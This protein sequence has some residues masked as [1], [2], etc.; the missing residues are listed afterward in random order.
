[1]LKDEI[2]STHDDVKENRQQ[3]KLSVVLMIAL[4]VLL[5]GVGAL[6]FAEMDA[7]PVVE[8]KPHNKYSQ[9]LR[10]LD[11]VD[12]CPYSYYDKNGKPTGY[13][14]EFCAELANR[15]QMNLDYRLI[16]WETVYDR[17]ARDE[18]DV[19]FGANLEETR[20]GYVYT[21]PVS[22]TPFMVY[23]K[24][25]IE[26]FTELFDK[27]I[28]VLT[29]T[30]SERFLK[31]AG[32]G[33]RL[34]PCKNYS[35]T[36]S[37]LQSGE[38][39]CAVVR[40]AC[41]SFI[42]ERDGIHDIKPQIPVVNSSLTMGLLSKNEKL[43][44]D[45]DAAIAGMKADG[46]LGRLREKWLHQYTENQTVHGVLGNSPVLLSVVIMAV[47][48]LIGLMIR[49]HMAQMSM[50]ETEAYAQTLEQNFDIIKI[51]ASEY[52]SVYYVDLLSGEIIPY[53]MNEE[54]E[55]ML[56]NLFNE[57]LSFSEVFRAYVENSVYVDDRGKILE[58]GRPESIKRELAGKKS[59]TVV[60]RRLNEKGIPVYC[61][62][63]FVKVGDDSSE[64]QAV[65]LGFANRDE[66]ILT[67][68][69]NNYIMSEYESVYLVD[70][71][72]DSF[73][74]IKKSGVTDVDD[75][76]RPYSEVM[77]AFAAYVA[78]KDKAF[79]RAISNPAYLQEY[80]QNS[81]RREFMYELPG[82]ERPLRRAIVQAVER[83]AGE[84]VRFF[85]IG[86]LSLDKAYA[87][88]LLLDAELAEKSEELVVLNGRLS[89]NE[90]ELRKTLSQVNLY[91]KAILS[92][93]CGYFRANL[94]RDRLDSHVFEVIDG[95]TCDVNDKLGITGE[96]GFSEFISMEGG[97]F[98]GAVAKN[99]ECKQTLQRDILMENYRNGRTMTDCT[100]WVD[101][102]TVGRRYQQNVCYVSKDEDT[103]DLL[104]VCVFYDK[105]AEFER[106]Q[107]E[108][109]FK[110]AVGILAHSYETAY[111]LEILSGNLSLLHC[112]IPDKK[113]TDIKSLYDPAIKEYIG[114]FIHPDDREKLL[115]WIEPEF[116]RRSLREQSEIQMSFRQIKDG[117][118][119]YYELRYIGMPDNQAI[120][121]FEDRTEQVK[122]QYQYQIELEDAKMRAEAAS[123]AKTTFL[124]NMSHDIRTPMNAIIG[125][126]GLALKNYNGDER[127]KAYLDKIMTSSKHLLSLI[128]DVLD[129][130]RIE[131]GRIELENA[132]CNLSEIMHNLNTIIVG[133]AVAKNQQ[134]FIDSYDVV[135]EY[136]YCDSLRLN[137]VLLNLLSNAVKYTPEG[138]E[139]RVILTQLKDAP[140]GYGKYELRV[141][142]NGMGMSPE[143]AAKVF[144]P[145]ERE[146]SEDVAKIQGTGLG[147]AITKNIVDMM[148][149]TIEVQ[150]E[151]GKGMEFIVTVEFAV[152]EGREVPADDF[153]LK[154]KRVLVLDDDFAVCD[155]VSR[156]LTQLGMRAEWTLRGQEALLRAEQAIG[157]QDDFY[158]FIIDWQMPDMSGMQVARRLRLLVG[159]EVPI[160]VLTAYDWT[161]IED[162]ARAVGVTNFCSKPVFL[163][164][165]E[166]VL[167]PAEVKAEEKKVDAE[168]VLKD[169][170]VLLVDDNELN[171]DIGFEVL[172]NFGL[173]VELAENGQEAVDIYSAAAA[174]YYDIILMDV[175]MPVLDGYGATEAIRALE[176]KEKA[177]VPI[178]AMTANAFASDVKEAIGHGMN[179]HLAK[180]IDVEK[181]REVM[182]KILVK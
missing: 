88:K 78:D 91:R 1:M 84:K 29:N 23:S 155:G 30:T 48:L 147:M 150:T 35:E 144:E 15:L 107:K 55:E 52:S 80:M 18:A 157:M 9:T 133:Q 162:D 69:V 81:D 123:V 109:M 134:L 143:F 129:M 50:R 116:I 54:N 4:V 100:C 98:A 119:R 46:T 19:V 140:K 175:Q 121:A 77:T 179:A 86:F 97:F 132:P 10:V 110:A 168:L 56:G 126:T 112:N 73:R 89:D 57:G 39:D 7:E 63:K 47:V 145:F 67:R 178:V 131:S 158:A 31:N 177:A 58:A 40:A 71:L 12:F 166:R 125:F 128:N 173:Q 59:F 142:D 22:S 136:V 66:E 65:A 3:H 21:T 160:I 25:R 92:Q 93:S 161:T 138:G 127:L 11:D 82:A 106:Q 72:D 83:N 181:L 165:L 122:Q 64:P 148:G 120:Q 171:R 180:P 75:E 130:S 172:S 95:V 8:I 27:K 152:Q 104:V 118:T 70:V 42:L 26:N 44:R 159:P 94:T 108:K 49:M 111:V 28:A 36:I 174:G 167:K 43:A 170:R 149:G 51:L 62:M 114:K 96:T 76:E 17:M 6:I 113:N 41:A 32:L 90:K 33:D 163:S 60:Y 16:S 141:R 87:E 124:S 99:V 5:A 101:S 154:G 68:Q 151:L 137:Q 135:N 176:D 14:V 24:L 153:D 169:R 102:P 146:K 45:I 13:D 38:C 103:G 61:E 105:T 139:I 85:V 164:D 117:E 53:V 156:M 34:V 2:K 37:R 74:I 182:I 79:I 115:Q 20:P